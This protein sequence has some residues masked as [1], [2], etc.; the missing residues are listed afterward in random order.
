MDGERGH[1]IS[2]DPT[3]FNKLAIIKEI[4]IFE[5][6]SWFTLNRIARLVELV[7]VRK[8]DVICKQG[9]PAD[10]FYAMASGRVS[11]FNVNSLGQR[12]EVDFLLR[13][14]HFGIISTL[15]GENHSHTYQ[16]AND[17]L[18]LKINKND[19]AALL[20]VTPKL[21]MAL[22]CSL[23]R[24][25]RSQSASADEVR[26]NALIAVHS[27]APDVGRSI[28]AANLAII[29]KEQSEGRK[30]LL[31]RFS[32]EPRSPLLN[33]ADIISSHPKTLEAICTAS[34][35]LDVLA[36]RFDAGDKRVIDRIGAFV[37][38]LVKDYDHIVFDIS[39]EVDAAVL[40]L[41]IQSDV[42]HLV[43]G[44]K[45]QDL[46]QV[47][48]TVETLSRELKDCF[49]P[50][51][52]QVIIG[53]STKNTAIDREEI[54]NT[55]KYD[56]LVILPFIAHATLYEETVAEGVVLTR[57]GTGTEYS[58]VL[59]RQCRQI[60]GTLIGLVLGGGAALGMAHVGVIR[61][62]EQE[63][64][65]V[66][67]VVGS[68]MGALIGAL[69]VTGRNADELESI[70]REFSK[71]TGLLKL[72]D[73]PI[74]RAL[75]LLGI[76]CVLWYCGLTLLAALFILMLI[77]LGL[78]PVSGI[79]KGKAIARWLRSRYGHTTFQDAR[80]PFK[81]VGYDLLHRRDIV[82]DQGEISDAVYKSIA[83]PGI[84][85]PV[86]EGGQM[87]IDGGVL[88]PLP[89]SVLS[90]MGIRKIIAVNV[91]QSPGEVSWGEEWE[92]K[93]YRHMA[94]V[95]F[96]RHPW[97][98]VSLRL[99][100][101]FGSFVSPNIAD[102]IVR[103]LQASEHVF[104]E[105]SGRQAN[106][107]IHPDLRGVQWFELYEVDKLIRRGY[108]AAMQR[109]PAIKAMVRKEKKTDSLHL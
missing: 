107:L 88:N 100:R 67:V 1:K 49:R 5:G 52:V 66:D 28:Y 60:R 29:L 15:T 70:A 75:V 50:G 80:I 74:Q 19:F 34:S 7:E 63:N 85:P 25:I 33:L 4:A 36:V 39:G 54:R 55:L 12:G 73:P 82:F 87:V 32:F 98:Y 58:F 23:S 40:K 20:Q 81:V 27:L 6:L 18:I 92:V 93:R 91:L 44:A 47:R 104:A 37:G 35:F 62:L 24:K 103:T 64:I 89:V 99:G 41:L 83:I 26:E 78:V 61:V 8:N 10:A 2:T 56:S 105:T 43:A 84:I 48:R 102:I 45:E 90:D 71:K 42:V 95:P 59:Q 3:F 21:A 13:G 65:P 69:W 97:K 51:N 76:S 16:A 11:A 53:R 38:G 101:Y 96:R 109:L 86:M 14:M 31:L 46:L 9:A 22:S 30:V 72:F 79:V 68:S 17:S 106:V 77:P 94:R 108:D 57:V